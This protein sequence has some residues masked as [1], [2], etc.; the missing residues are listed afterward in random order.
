MR[1]EDVECKTH[2]VSFREDALRRPVPAG[3]LR[4]NCS[5]RE[6]L[7]G[8]KSLEPFRRTWAQCCRPRWVSY[9]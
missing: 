3:V 4:K 1:W 7:Q 8:W 6:A 5:S 9:R 2:R